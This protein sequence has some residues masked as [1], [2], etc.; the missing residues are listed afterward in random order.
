MGEKNTKVDCY[1]GGTRS[2]EVW[3]LI[4]TLKRD[5]INKVNIQPILIRQWKQH[6]SKE[7]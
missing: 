3:K 5:S 4:K 6:Y 2:S 7:L 1:I